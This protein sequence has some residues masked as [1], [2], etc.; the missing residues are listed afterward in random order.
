MQT[1]CVDETNPENGDGTKKC[2]AEISYRG[3]IFLF[4]N[5]FQKDR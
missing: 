1:L 2:F 3:K 5:L 4:P